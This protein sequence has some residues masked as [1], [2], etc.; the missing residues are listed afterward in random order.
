LEL[1]NLGVFSSSRAL[2]ILSTPMTVEDVD[3]A[4]DAFERTLKL[5]KPC[6]A[7]K[8]PHLL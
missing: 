3:S 5:L 2:Y 7:E 4:V 6:V 1:L 8:A